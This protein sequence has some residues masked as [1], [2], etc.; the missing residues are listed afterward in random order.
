[1]AI[2][3]SRLERHFAKDT[4]RFQ[5]GFE[6]V[7]TYNVCKNLVVDHATGITVRYSEIEEKIEKLIQARRYEKLLRSEE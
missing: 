5:A 3:K 1:M 6:R 7:R 2:L 4:E